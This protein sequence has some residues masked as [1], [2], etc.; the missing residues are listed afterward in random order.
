[1][2]GRLFSGDEIIAVDGSPVLNTSHH[3]VVSFMGQAAQSGRV[4]LTVRRRLY[5]QGKKQILF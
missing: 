1:M 5:Q 3:E 4:T 2:D